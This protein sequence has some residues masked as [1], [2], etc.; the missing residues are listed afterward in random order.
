MLL[1]RILHQKTFTNRYGTRRT[2]FR[3][4]HL[5]SPKISC[6]AT[7]Q[8]LAV[9]TALLWVERSWLDFHAGQVMTV[10][11]HS[12]DSTGF[13]ML[14]CHES[15]VVQN[16]IYSHLINK[17]VEHKTKFGVQ[18]CIQSNGKTSPSNKHKCML[19]T[20]YQPS[21]RVSS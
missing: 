16:K 13:G 18:K 4:Q 8:T 1:L 12:S 11:I 17:D 6:Q 10:T 9:S 3:N 15:E 19:K 20:K 21:D 7:S 2:N 14:Q 5:F